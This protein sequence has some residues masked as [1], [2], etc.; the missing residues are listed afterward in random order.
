MQNKGIIL[1][2]STA[3]ISGVSIFINQFGVKITNPYIFT[4]FKNILVA[5]LLTVVILLF[6][7]FKQIK[8]LSKKNWS[9]LIIIG[10]I[11]GSIPFLMFF[12]GLSLSTAPEASYL[13]K[14]LFIFIALLAPFI[15][16]EKIRWHYLLGLAMLVLGSIFLFK[17][18]GHFTLNSG[19]LL[20][21]GATVLWACENIIAKKYIQDISPKIIAW[22]RMFFGSLF[23]IL[24]WFMTNQVSFI[25]TLQTPQYFWIIIT[26]VLLFGYVVTWYSSLKYLPVTYAA[27]I[28]ALGAP[29]TSALEL[30]QG[31][32]IAGM[33]IFGMLLMFIA[34]A[35]FLL[36]DKKICSPLKTRAVIH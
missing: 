14:Y 4:G 11:G 32:Q 19:N 18:N 20:I 17:V 1:A 33:Q 23:I 36:I 35:G 24:Y 15:L 3:L 8:K 2:F 30:I 28:L 21:I 9:I 22:G 5:I 12:K 13:H 31:K 25:S 29:I 26:S 16:K 10:L 27:A 6:K 7:E 34:V